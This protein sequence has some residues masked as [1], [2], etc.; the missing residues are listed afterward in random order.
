MLETENEMIETSHVSILP[1]ALSYPICF[2]KHPVKTLVIKKTKQVFI[3][4]RRVPQ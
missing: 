3:K 4:V 2:L 1:L